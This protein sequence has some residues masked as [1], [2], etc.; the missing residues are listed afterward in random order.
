MCHSPQLF[1]AYHVF[2]RLLVP[3]HPPCALI[4]SSSE[5]VAFFSNFSN[6]YGLLLVVSFL[7][8]FF[9][10]CLDYLNNHLI[11][12]FQYSIFKVQ[13]KVMILYKVHS[14][15][16]RYTSFRSSRVFVE[17]PSAHPVKSSFV[18]AHSLF[19]E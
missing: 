16:I 7:T 17:Y 14:R 2:R 1:A 13:L 6:S 15:E 12:S 5:A 11:F 18:Q 10:G 8:N 4:A 3:R 9:L 19:P